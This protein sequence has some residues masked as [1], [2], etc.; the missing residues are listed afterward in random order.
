MNYNF[1]KKEYPTWI[2]ATES[3]PICLDMT[4]IILS[5]TLV[6]VHSLQLVPF[7]GIAA[8]GS[9]TFLVDHWLSLGDTGQKLAAFQLFHQLKE[10]NFKINAKFTLNRLS[11]QGFHSREKYERLFHTDYVNI[12]PFP[13]F[14]YAFL[15]YEHAYYQKVRKFKLRGNIKFLN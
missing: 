4:D 14:Q 8:E 11:V 1:N 7:L 5:W 2:R 9:T 3:S 6:I 10:E 13:I 15:L 12:E